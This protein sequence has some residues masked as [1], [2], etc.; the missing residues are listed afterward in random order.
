MNQT[1][2]VITC[3]NCAEPILISEINCRIFRH[4]TLIENGQQI[5]P[6][7]SLEVCTV[8]L[9]TNKIYGCGKP[10]QLVQNEKNE[11]VAVVCG[12]I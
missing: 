3:P 6:H 2:F 5:D 10:F 12:Y 4:A 8:L 9:E 11:W 7:S 1:D